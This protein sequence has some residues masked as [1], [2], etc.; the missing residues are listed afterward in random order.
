ML[1]FVYGSTGDYWPEIDMSTAFK[2]G[3]AKEMYIST[4]GD[5]A[6]RFFEELENEQ[7]KERDKKIQEALEEERRQTEEKNV[8]NVHEAMYKIL[9]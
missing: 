4:R 5:H 3:V 8:I 1:P 9:Q 2:L 7:A 6:E